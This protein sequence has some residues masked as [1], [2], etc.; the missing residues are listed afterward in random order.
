[1]TNHETPKEKTATASKINNSGQCALTEAGSRF[2]R[3]ARSTQDKIVMPLA[4]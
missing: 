1:L 3:T 2:D 4:R